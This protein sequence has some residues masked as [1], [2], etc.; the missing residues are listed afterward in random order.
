MSG[1]GETRHEDVLARKASMGQTLR[2][3]AWSF[4]GVR[5]RADYEADV[6]KLNPV[7][8]VVAGIIGG[9]VFIALLVVVVQW[10]VGSGVAR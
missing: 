2:A 6:S 10:V 5:R 7:H 3:V 4:F 1:P 9:A 8:V